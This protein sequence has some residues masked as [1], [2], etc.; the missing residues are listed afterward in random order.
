[1]FL[2]FSCLKS[3]YAIK[4]LMSDELAGSIA[5]RIID[6]LAQKSPALRFSGQGCG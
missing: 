1:M 5:G 4:M 2:P 3:K 6:M